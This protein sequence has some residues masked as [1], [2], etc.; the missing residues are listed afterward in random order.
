MSYL[1]DPRV[2]IRSSFPPPLE[3]IMA[4]SSSRLSID[5]S[6]AD[7]CPEPS[8]AEPSGCWELPEEPDFGLE[9]VAGCLSI[10]KAAEHEIHEFPLSP[11]PQTG[12]REAGQEPHGSLLI[13]LEHR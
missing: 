3:T 13:P 10:P 4:A 7:M 1:G 5:D 9:T 6:D 2:R 8:Q 12:A 11:D